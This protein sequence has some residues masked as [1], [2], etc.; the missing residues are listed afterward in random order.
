MGEQAGAVTT[1]AREWP[2]EGRVDELR[3]V[4][5]ALRT[6]RGVVLAGAAGV[7]KTRLARE[8]ARAT[9]LPARWVSATAA[10]RSVPLGAFAPVVGRST[11][12]D[13]AMRALQQAG[14]LLVVDDA[15]LLDEV[16]A[17]FLHQVVLAGA[18]TVVVTLCSGEPAPDAVRALWKDEVLPRLEVLPL[19]EPQTATLVESV[20]GGPADG[21]CRHRLWS[22]SRGNVLQ[23]RQLVDGTRGSRLRPVHDVWRWEGD[24]GI[25]PGLAEIVDARIGRLCADERLVLEILALGEPL[26]VALLETLADP[27]AIDRVEQRGLVTVEIDG[28]RVGCRLAHPLY[29]EVLRGRISVRRA[30]RL[31]GALAD[32]IK[33]TGAARAGDTLRRAVLVLD[34]DLTPDPSLFATAAREAIALHDLPLAARLARAAWEWGPQ[35]DSGLALAQ[36]LSWQG[37]AAEADAVLDGVDRLAEA[38]ADRAQATA[39][40]VANRHFTMRRPDE[41]GRLLQSSP[42]SPELDGLRATLTAHLGRIPEAIATAT[43]VLTRDDAGAYARTW[44]AYGLCHALGRAGRLAEATTAAST[45]R[46]GGS[47]NALQIAQAE[48]TGLCLAGRLARAGERAERLGVLAR[49]STGPA[50]PMTCVLAAQ[51]DL[52][53]GRLVDGVRRLREA[54]A[55][56]DGH[57]PGAF[58]L[59]AGLLLPHAL[60][61]LGD[62]AAARAAQRD[63]EDA[64]YPGVVMIEPDLVL[65]RAWVAAA[66]GVPREAAAH[67][68][69]SAGLAA[70]GGQHAVEV[71]ALHTAV[72]LGDPTARDR[73]AVLAELVEGPQ[74]RV[75]ADHATALAARDPGAL[76]AVS[77]A[78]QEMGALLIAADA[79]AQ[80]SVLHDRAGHRRPAAADASRAHDLARRCGGADTPALRALTAS[81]LTAREREVVA[82]A[83]S[84][85]SNQD[86]AARLV[87][88]VRTVEGHLYRAFAKLGVTDRGELHGRPE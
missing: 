70:A 64:H 54:R 19:S 14:R 13:A 73:L 78:T 15:H 37:R 71:L 58:T 76:R 34:S 20:L 41:A 75:A 84:G 62:A 79:A 80:A 74:P 16:S 9:R 23:L 21:E 40:R 4:R 49:R 57:E 68:R 63:A 55:G 77:E 27:A 31:R 53:R 88:S 33:G 50:R 22:L 38:T 1:A 3:F 46:R 25:G 67:A 29:G 51:V 81:S 5:S 42:A 47:V 82:L 87:V 35:P 6:H 17:A 52:G 24:A 11:T 2:L 26:G 10:A 39:L 59:Y 30:R 72:C 44:A 86:V 61:M 8:A 12:P 45:A 36:L 32:A 69:R 43:A 60:G 28:R 18:A 48:I 85:L 66:E 7:G 83:A 65:G 56:V